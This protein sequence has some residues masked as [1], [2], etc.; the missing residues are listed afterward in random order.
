MADSRGG[1]DIGSA[2]AMAPA[3]WRG[4]IA[5]LLKYIAARGELAQIEVHEATT[6]L[7]SAAL[8]GIIFSVLLFGAWVLL[9]P[10]LV[11][12]VCDWMGW[13]LDRALIIT[14]ASHVVL[15]FIFL[16]AM[17]NR[18]A[19]ARWF[20]ETLG[21]FKKDRAWIVQETQKP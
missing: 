2:E 4:V 20:T 19:R 6:H 12:L 5:A 16:K 14:G 17:L 1:N 8:F 18:L 21:Q 7:V 11:W 15:A 3:A 10:A 13:P 9:V